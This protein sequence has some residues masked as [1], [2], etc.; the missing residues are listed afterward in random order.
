[1]AWES[2]HGQIKYSIFI[3]AIVNLVEAIIVTHVHNLMLSITFFLVFMLLRRGA[4]SEARNV[5]C[6]SYSKLSTLLSYSP[7]II[8]II[9]ER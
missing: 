9:I 6:F 3:S 7:D 8:V 4:P 2:R 5:I 1:M